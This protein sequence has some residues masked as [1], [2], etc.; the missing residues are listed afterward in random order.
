MT[1]YFH[2]IK[3]DTEPGTLSA[4]KRDDG[5]IVP[6]GGLTW[7]EFTKYRTACLGGFRQ[8][9]A[10]N[11]RSAGL[12]FWAKNLSALDNLYP[13]WIEAANQR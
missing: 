7:Q 2:H 4:I 10:L 13:D 6:L 12:E 3:Q 11:Y 5:T 1:L 9:A 8:H